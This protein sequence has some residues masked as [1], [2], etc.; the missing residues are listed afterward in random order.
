MCYCSCID[1]ADLSDIFMKMADG[2]DVVTKEEFITFM[3]QR[4]IA[5][6]EEEQV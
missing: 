4:Y 1:A 6:S 3:V 5:S 2:D